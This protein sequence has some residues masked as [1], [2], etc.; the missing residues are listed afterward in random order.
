M[1]SFISG[2]A[3]KCVG[4]FLGVNHCVRTGGGAP[5]TG[6]DGPHVRRGGESRRRRLD[7]ALGRDPIREERS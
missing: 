6:A 5:Y 3:K 1:K 2:V 4:A 7:L